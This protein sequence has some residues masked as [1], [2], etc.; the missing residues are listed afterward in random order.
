MIPLQ[1]S[2]LSHETIEFVS[3]QKAFFGFINC[4]IDS[5]LGRIMFSPTN[6]QHFIPIVIALTDVLGNSEDPQAKKVC[7]STLSTIVREF[8]PSTINAQSAPI[9][10]GENQQ[11][12]NQVISSSS[13][14]KTRKKN[15]EMSKDP[16]LIND[17]PIEM[18]QLLVRTIYEKVTP[19]TFQALSP[20]GFNPSEGSHIPTLVSICQLHMYLSDRFGN[21]W[22]DFLV[23]IYLPSI[24]CP[25]QTAIEYGNAVATCSGSHELRQIFLTLFFNKPGPSN[26][27]KNQSKT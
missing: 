7:A 1:T 15:V 19:S 24:N 22:L 25:P 14:M 20:P 13:V 8:F 16:Q 26:S 3:L 12:S 17:L 21:E 18:K 11:G 9:Q 27:N 6:Q 5:G 4:I 10:N 23:R 2:T